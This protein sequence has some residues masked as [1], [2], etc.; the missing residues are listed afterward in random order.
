MQPHS[1]SAPHRRIDVNEI[2]Q[3][4]HDALGED[5][6][7]Y[8]KAVGAYLIGQIAKEELANM[9]RGWLKGKDGE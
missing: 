4:L 6:L 2:K 3:Q 5:G 8:W 7:P 1:F 9:V